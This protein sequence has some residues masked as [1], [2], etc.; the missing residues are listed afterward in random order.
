MA[1]YKLF[2]DEY[3]GD[4]RIDTLPSASGRA[5]YKRLDTD[6]RLLFMS[7]GTNWNFVGPVVDA[8]REHLG[9][10]DASS[11]WAIDPTGWFSDMQYL[12]NLTPNLDGNGVGHFIGTGTGG[13]NS[14]AGFYILMAVGSFA[15]WTRPNFL[16]QVIFRQAIP[17]RS[18][19]DC[20]QIYGFYTGVSL[21]AAA[22][23]NPLD[24]NNGGVLIAY[25]TDDTNWQIYVG[26]GDGTTAVSSPIDTGIAVPAVAQGRVFDIQFLTA[27]NCLVTLRDSSSFAVVYTTSITTNLP[28]GTKSLNFLNLINNP[29]NVNKTLSP[30]GGWGRALR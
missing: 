22:D 14:W 20:R 12:G 15:G 11:R 7:D 25:D 4:S 17:A 23:G 21:P 3:R 2:F 5:G 9:R 28:G 27:T 8:T 24:V 19:G 1:L 30:Y 10:Y 13:T 26:P 16:P 6:T 29:T 18:S